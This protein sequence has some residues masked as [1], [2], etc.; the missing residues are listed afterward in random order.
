M[1]F[2]WL[3]SGGSL[4]VNK[5]P[6]VKS[7][8]QTIKI[9]RQTCTRWPYC[10]GLSGGRYP[11]AEAE[12]VNSLQRAAISDRTIL[13][14]GCASEQSKVLESKHLTFLHFHR[15]TNG[16]LAVVESFGHPVITAQWNITDDWAIWAPESKILAFGSF[17]KLIFIRR[18]ALNGFYGNL[19]WKLFGHEHTGVWIKFWRKAKFLCS[20][21]LNI[22]L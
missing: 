9:F 15:I 22:R 16:R 2:L 18:R 14:T 4:L 3:F 13:L 8:I 10:V 17:T 21:L 12:A 11:S 7:L 6:L 1:Q 20:S 19:H 5:Q